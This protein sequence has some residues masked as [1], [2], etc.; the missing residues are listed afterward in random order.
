MI[1]KELIKELSDA[2]EKAKSK[3]FEAKIGNSEKVEH[4]SGTYNGLSIAR[5]IVWKYK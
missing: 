1:D 5:D 3:Y 4:I 2:F